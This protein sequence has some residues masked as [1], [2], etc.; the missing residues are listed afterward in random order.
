MEES[1]KGTIQ[2]RI[3]GAVVLQRKGFLFS[4]DEKLEGTIFSRGL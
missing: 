3:G 4:L 2:R 1:G